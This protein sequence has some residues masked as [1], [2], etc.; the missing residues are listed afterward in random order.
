MTPPP[1]VLPG[2]QTGFRKMRRR[3]PVSDRPVV[4]PPAGSSLPTR[5][6][7]L[8]EQTP[9]TVYV[10]L[11]W[12]AV[13]H[14]VC[15]MSVAGKVLAQFTIEHTAEG[16]ASLIS[17]LAKYG[18]PAEVQV[19]IERPNGRLVDLLLEAGHPV[20]P[21][22]PNAIKTWREGEVVSGAK[23]DAGDALVIAEYLRLRHHR[24]HPVAPYCA[25]TKA[26]RTVVRTRD[27]IVAMRVAAT[28]QLTA[29]LDSYWP[30]ATQ[31]FAD[32]QS[33]ISLAFLRQYPTAAAAAHLGEKRLATFLTEQGY[34]GRRPTT[35]LLA[36]LRRA[37]VGT[38][39]PVLTT[40]VQD[41]VGALLTVLEA[42][43]TAG[44]QLDRSVITHLGEHP[45][46]EIFTSLPRSGQI[47]AAQV[48]AEWGDSRAAYDSPE[49]IAALAGVSPVTKASGKQRAVHFR[50]ACNKRFRQ[51][52][53]TFADNSRHTSPWAANIYAQARARNHDHPH[54]IR[55]L[56][57]AWIRVIY[58]C[59]HNQKPYDPNLHGGAQ[60]LPTT[61]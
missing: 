42:L 24:L 9:E 61:A 60:R 7:L 5:G 17:R 22:T 40:A 16:V 10:G 53:T 43:N 54:A 30:G 11:D 35:E 28:N 31:I 50:W 55:I 51:A 14:A 46:T 4:D 48:L 56:A 29:L 47:N 49:A 38:T 25:Q 59:W 18:D 36:R 6:A 2:S 21:V 13:S 33:P 26:L 52:I 45:D 1:S 44:K 23:S 32:I 41:A 27:D 57:R 58:R 39:D 3:A 15:V 20:I 8:S 19:G 34:S 37:P 12:A